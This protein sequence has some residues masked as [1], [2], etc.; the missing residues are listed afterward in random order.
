MIE[1]Q[2]H[3]KT[4]SF[5]PGVFQLYA[6]AHNPVAA[7]LVFSVLARALPVLS[8]DGPADRDR[9]FVRTAF[10]GRGILDCFEFACRGTQ[11]GRL[12][13]DLECGPSDAPP[14]PVG[15]CCFDLFLG[16]D[17][18]SVWPTRPLFS[19]EFSALA[20]RRD[21]AGLTAEETRSLEDGQDRLS[22]SILRQA[23]GDLL[24]LRPIA[25]PSSTLAARGPRRSAYDVIHVLDQDELT[26]IRFADLVRYHGRFNIGGV[27]LGLRVLQYAFAQL[28]PNAVPRRDAV[29][30]FTA[31]PGTG[32]RDAFEMITRAVTA[33]R[34]RLD[35]TLDEPRAPVAA[36]GR[37]Y[38][39][40]SVE[41]RTLAFAPL[42]ELIP[43]DLA[44]LARQSREAPLSPRDAHRLKEI[45]E[46][47][48]AALLAT[49]PA[50]IFQNL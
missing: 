10:P 49:P 18:C 20:R 34:F 29:S 17:G 27:A 3:G 23:P 2:D 1:L 30:I 9:L 7:A 33:G 12:W 37:F 24:T 14:A 8:P 35:E 16:D 46:G 13:V 50:A 5:G 43:A 48:A 22:R 42:P 47:L 40:V 32:A 26:T 36:R 21:N 45:K 25:P 11:D 38:F 31:F 6:G 44:V 41:D 39:R 28:S 4:L 19:P 15:R